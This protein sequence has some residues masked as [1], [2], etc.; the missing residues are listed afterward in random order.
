MNVDEALRRLADPAGFPKDAMEWALAHWDE[1]AP[2]FIGRLRAWATRGSVPPEA[3]DE[4]FFILHLCG[5]KGEAG[6]YEPL[7]RLIASGA[8]PHPWLGD[9]V[10][11]TLPGIFIKLFDGDAE[12]LVR[13]IESPKGDAFAQSSAL[14]ALA[15][16]VRARG[17]MNDEDMRGL[18][19]K[20]S[21]EAKPSDD[22]IFWMTWAE[23]AAKLG[24]E[25]LR[26]DLARLN[27]EGRL[28]RRE[29]DL[30][31]FNEFSRP[32]GAIPAILPSSN[33]CRLSRSR[34]RSARWRS[35]TTATNLLMKKASPIRTPP[36]MRPISIRS[37]TS[38]A[39]I[40]APAGAARNTRSAASP[41]RACC[42]Q[43]PSRSAVSC[44]RTRASFGG[45]VRR[46]TPPMMAPA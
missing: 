27:A 43:T 10:T 37:A 19:H 30:A 7:C 22:M 1:A 9:A 8:D 24:Y 29:Y 12:P 6:A 4:A 28:E 32:R 25:D 5:D 36:S 17:A 11:E 42:R 26:A 40:R 3:A 38:A 14:A 21:R 35:G 2:R 23:A 44:P 15:Y 34:M 31:A 41:L 18:L 46:V 33:R 13:V 16:L 45:A 39:T 20:L